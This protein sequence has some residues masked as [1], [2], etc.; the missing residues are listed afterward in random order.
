MIDLIKTQFQIVL[1]EL[2]AFVNDFLGEENVVLPDGCPYQKDIEHVSKCQMGCL[3]QIHLIAMEEVVREAKILA[4]LEKLQQADKI[5]AYLDCLR[6]ISPVLLQKCNLLLRP[7]N[8]DEAIQMCL[9]LIETQA[10]SIVVLDSWFQL[11]LR[12]EE[13]APLFQNNGIMRHY[14]FEKA[15]TKLS[16][17]SQ[18]KLVTVLLF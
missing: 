18:K 7:N 2:K 1:G 16:Q 8:A 9:K 3:V 14:F 10:V 12:S 5:V 15:M 13:N 4:I 6:N 17:S 11:P